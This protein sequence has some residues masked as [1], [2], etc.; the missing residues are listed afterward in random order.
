MLC[1]GV[2]SGTSCDGVDVALVEI[3]ADIKVTQALHTGY[4]DALKN[5]LLQLI[6]NQPVPTADVCQLDVELARC[7]A[8]AID[9]LLQ[10]AGLSPQDITAVGLHGQTIWHHPSQALANTWQLGSAA[11]TAAYSGITTVA[12][13]RQLDMAHGGQ[14]APLAPAL[15][16]ELFLSANQT[17]AVI[18]LGGIANITWLSEDSV[19]GFDV[20]P[21]SCLMDG[22]VM[23]HQSQPYDDQGQWAASGQV[24]EPLLAE[25][26]QE[27]FLHLPG[28]KST[29]RELF[30]LQ[31]LDE[32]LA[33]TNYLPEDIQRTL[34]QFT[35]ECI[36]LG[37]KQVGQA[38][39]QVVV[40]GGGTHNRQLMLTL[41]EALEVPCQSSAAFG[42]DPD[43]VEATLM[44]WM[45]ERHL[46]DQRLDLRSITGADKPLLYGVR[47][48]PA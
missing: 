29:G 18:N 17:V 28:P 5:K 1:I 19:I 31:W 32:H 21:A 45:A 34:L 30:N 33:G 16:R 36:K 42:V 22:W 26:L 48:E 43:F 2:M 24:V 23:R 11:A 39:D 7:Y 37:F 12:N 40:C 3:N 4:P 13:F 27:P 15:H 25:L 44:A 41:A 47:Y 38:V 10:T 8:D 35:V 9:E 14:G 46:A 6:Q 20:G